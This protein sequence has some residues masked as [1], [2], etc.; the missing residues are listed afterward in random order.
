[1]SCLAAIRYQSA[2]L[3]LM[4]IAVVFMVS[5]VLTVR[6]LENVG[7]GS[8]VALSSAPTSAPAPVSSSAS[9]RNVVLTK[10]RN[11]HFQVEARVDGRRV[12]FLVDTGASHIALRESEANRLGIYPRPSDYTVR[13]STANGVTKAALVQLRSVEVGDI[14]VRDVSAIV[15]PDEGLSVNLL[16][17]TFLSRVRF[18]HER[19]KLMLEQ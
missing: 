2:M 14:V 7:P 12:E 16:G 11:G 15:H 5:A 4:I 3:R 1:M 6:H 19:G 17:M 9:A 13:V 18:A 10:A 8:T